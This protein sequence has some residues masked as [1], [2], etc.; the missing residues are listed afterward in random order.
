MDSSHIEMF[1][2][3]ISFPTVNVNII[4]EVNYLVRLKKGF[5]WL[6]LEVADSNL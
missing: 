2:W 1:V 3:Q 6:M 5:H 4:K